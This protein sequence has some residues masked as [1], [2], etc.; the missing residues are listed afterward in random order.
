MESSSP[1]LKSKVQRRRDL[2]SRSR[3]KN[4]LI[5]IVYEMGVLCDGEIFLGIT[6]RE[7]GKVTTFCTDPNGTHKVILH[8]G[9]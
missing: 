6:V 4:G 3:R 2:Q 8:P 5:H 9:V 1:P 7:T